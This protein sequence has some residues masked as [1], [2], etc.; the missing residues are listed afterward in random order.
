MVHF[1][2]SACPINKL[3]FSKIVIL[4]NENIGCCRPSVFI[5]NNNFDSLVQKE[6]LA[7]KEQVEKSDLRE[8]QLKDTIEELRQQVSILK[9]SAGEM[10]E[11]DKKEIE[12]KINAYIK[13]IDRCITLLSE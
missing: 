8:S 13:E 6:N 5:P 4:S 3:P 11:T 1:N 10:T 7:L 2:L 9:L 12:K